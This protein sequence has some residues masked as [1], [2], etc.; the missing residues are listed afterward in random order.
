MSEDL[1]CAVKDCSR[2]GVHVQRLVLSD[3]RERDPLV[4]VSF[5]NQHF[6]EQVTGTRLD[7]DK[8]KSFKA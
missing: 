4:M 6:D 3:L 2:A 5:C 1:K 7:F 8:S